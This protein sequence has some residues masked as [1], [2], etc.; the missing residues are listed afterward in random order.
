M[1]LATREQAQI[2]RSRAVTPEAMEHY[3]KARYM[4]DVQIDLKGA[5]ELLQR[6]IQIAPAMRAKTAAI[7]LAERAGRQCEEHLLPD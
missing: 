3:L 4:M 7:L 5:V 2:S 6:A 1:I